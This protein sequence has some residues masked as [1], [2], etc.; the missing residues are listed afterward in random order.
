MSTSAGQEVSFSRDGESIDAYLAPAG[1][2][3]TAAL[4]LI[5]D[6]HGLSDHYRDVARRFA[7]AGFTTLAIDLYTR[8][9]K[10]A[11]ADMDAIVAW[12]N[13]LDDRRVLADLDAAAAYL[14]ARDDIDARRV[15]I[16]G[17][18]MGGQYALMAACSSD[19]FAA[20]VSWYGMLRYAHTP[21]HKPASPLTLAA[22]LRCPYLGLFG[23]DDPIIPSADV[24]ELRSILHSGGKTFAIEIYQGAG[25]AFFNDSRPETYRPEVAKRAWPRAVGFLRSHL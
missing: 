23:A 12:M 13:A 6:V 3:G 17:F 9:G 7:A 22:D 21:A 18:C 20:A 8:E 10:P 4:V 14:G 25:H 16:T 2:A 1:S 24:E 11:L 15:G 19:G 5:P